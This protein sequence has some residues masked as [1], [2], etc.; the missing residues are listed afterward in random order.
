MNR[1]LSIALGLLLAAGLTVAL[2][3]R[4]MATQQELRTQAATVHQEYLVVEQRLRELPALRQTVADLE[5]KS[6]EAEREFPA[7]E[8]LGLLI[9]RLQEAAAQ[10]NLTVRSITRA[11][12]PSALPG[13]TEVQLTMKLNGKYPD[14]MQLL[15]WTHEERRVLSVTQIDSSNGR[16]HQLSITGYTRD[17]RVP[18]VTAAVPEG[19]QP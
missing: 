1:T 19:A 17:S 11:T 18:P 7:E 15:D 16:E 8:N 4:A 9:A 14:V 6:E 12:Q 10:Q 13:F 3:P 5:V 2:T